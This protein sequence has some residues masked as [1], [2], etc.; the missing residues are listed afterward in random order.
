MSNFPQVYV[1]GAADGTDSVTLDSSG[2]TFV[3]TPSFS[4]ASGTVERRELPVGGLV[5]G[6]CHGPGGRQQRYGRFLQLSVGYLHR[7]DRHQFARRQHTNV[8][9]SSV[10]FV[11]QASG[12]SSV[13]V[14][15]S[16][17]GT[18]TANLTSPGSGSFF[19]TSTASTLTVGTSTS[20]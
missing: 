17:A 18:D 5:R 7:R 6:E 8:A 20:R 16:G 10:N 3:S 15:E 2:G 11:S 1:V 14:F 19:G 4:Y 9:G 13:S 12:Y